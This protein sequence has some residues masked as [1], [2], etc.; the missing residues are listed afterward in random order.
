MTH[1]PNHDSLWSRFLRFLN[2]DISTFFLA[3]LNK[4]YTPLPEEILALDHPGQNPSLLPLPLLLDL[5]LLDKIKDRRDALN[6]R[7]DLI[8]KITKL[9][10][11][12]VNTYSDYVEDMMNDIS[13]WRSIFPLPA[14]ETLR[15]SFDK[16]I[17]YKIHKKMKLFELQILKRLEILKI[18][19][20]ISSLQNE[21]PDPQLNCIASY[22]FKKNNKAEILSAINQ[23]VNGDSGIIRMYQNQIIK[24]SQEVIQGIYRVN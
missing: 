17:R 11:N 18:Q 19:K 21:M 6:F 15:H 8:Q 10:N 7:D 20:N 2:R 22:K 5:T 14:N 23:L 12:Y 13:V 16:M 1:L 4:P 24:I 9:G 3:P